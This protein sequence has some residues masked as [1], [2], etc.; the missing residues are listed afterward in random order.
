[1]GIIVISFN[2]L[3]AHL[4]KF[5]RVVT[6]RYL[7][8]LNLGLVDWYFYPL[9]TR[10]FRNRFVL[11]KHQKVIFVLGRI[12]KS[13]VLDIGPFVAYRWVFQSNF[14]FLTLSI[15]FV[16]GYSFRSAQDLKAIYVHAF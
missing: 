12:W 7:I 5:V 8:Q 3:Y 1:M 2:L 11:I 13:L 4:G 6:C 16:F 14:E 10:D 15:S 9:L